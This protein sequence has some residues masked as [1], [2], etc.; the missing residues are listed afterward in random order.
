MRI[1]FGFV[2]SLLCIL[3]C[4][5][6]CS[7]GKKKSVP[8]QQQQLSADAVADQFLYGGTATIYDVAKAQ[9]REQSKANKKSSKGAKSKDV[10]G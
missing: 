4:E 2:M 10:N 9:L 7:D 1:G 3:S 6:L 5:S 8:K